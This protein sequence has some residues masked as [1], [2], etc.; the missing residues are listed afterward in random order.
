[1]RSGLARL[2]SS[3]ALTALLTGVAAAS[4]GRFI[5]SLDLSKPFGTRSAWRLTAYQGPEIQNPIGASEDKVPGRV[6]LCLSD[7][8]ER[9]CNSTL[10]RAL[11]SSAGDDLFS[12]PHFLNEARVVYAKSKRALLL[13]QVS[14]LHSG[15]GDQRV[16][17]QVFAYERA[18]DRFVSIYQHLTE[19]NNNQ[20]VRYI[21]NGSLKGDIIVVE[22]TNDAPFGYW[23]TVDELTASITYRRVLHYRSA[24]RYADGN[25]LAVI[26]SEMP[27]IEQRLGMWR[28]GLPL[29]IPAGPCPKPHLV[30]LELWCL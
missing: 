6:D 25:P 11:R 7:D 16:A 29:P 28:P 10:Q 12:E 27:N 9:S 26:D 8:N 1:M 19:R 15:D 2:A 14:S 21:V 23:I 30:K 3:I 17:T 5:L 18:K 24:T 13:V 22:P 4:D 20:E